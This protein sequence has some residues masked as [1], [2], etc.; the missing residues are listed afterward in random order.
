[1]PEVLCDYHPHRNTAPQIVQQFHLAFVAQ[2]D[3]LHRQRMPNRSRSVMRISTSACFAFWDEKRILH[4][5]R[6][7]R[8]ATHTAPRCVFY[9]IAAALL[10]RRDIQ[11][12]KL[13]PEAEKQRPAIEVQGRAESGANLNLSGNEAIAYCLKVFAS[14]LSSVKY[15]LS[16]EDGIAQIVG[17]GGDADTNTSVA[18]AML[19]AKFGFG[20]ISKEFVDLMFV[21]QGL[22]CEMSPY[23]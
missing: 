20:G 10:I 9:T 16:F 5:A 1:M 12:F 23:L 22:W 7:F 8:I 18:G 17:E 15:E 21:G 3:G 4:I 11:A 6:Q 19:R 13:V 2:P 14:G